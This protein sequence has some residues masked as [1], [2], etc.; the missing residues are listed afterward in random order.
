MRYIFFDVD[1]VLVDGYNARA[2]RR[3]CWDD[4]LERDYPEIS[5]TEF[6]KAFFA[7]PFVEKVLI[8]RQD[9]AVTLEQTFEQLGYKTD[10]EEFI[11]F[12][13]RNDSNISEPL[14]DK[15]KILKKSGQIRLYIATNQEH[16][17]AAYLMNELGFS[18]YFEDIFYSARIGHLKPDPNY[19]SYISDALDLK[20]LP[21]PPIF[22]DDRIEVVEGALQAGWEAYE[23]IDVES[24]YQCPYVKNILFK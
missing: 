19:F 11:N 13:M 1:G 8:G 12:W 16:V 5:K 2:E 7:G 20:K 22:F 10:P 9:L 21:D 23:Y 14:L 6:K 18:K 17:R 3:K 24:L 15:V 4:H